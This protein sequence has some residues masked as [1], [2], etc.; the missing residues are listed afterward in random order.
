MFN[1]YLN[2]AN[3]YPGLPQ[4]EGFPEILD[5]KSKTENP[6]QRDKLISIYLTEINTVFQKKQTNGF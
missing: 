2:M 3:K 1:W 6:R 4:T 5:F